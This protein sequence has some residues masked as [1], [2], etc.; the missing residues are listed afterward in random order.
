VSIKRL[1]GAGIYGSKSNKV[2]DQTTTLNDFQSIATVV[3]PSG[4]QS[5]VTFSNI[6]STFTHLQVRAICS[7]SSAPDFANLKVN[8]DTTGS[9]YARHLLYADGG[10]VTAAASTGSTIT[11]LGKISNS[12]TIMATFIVDILDYANANKNKTI[13]SLGGYDSN[14]S[15]EID[16]NSILWMN[17]NAITSLQFTTY[18]SANFVQ[19]SSF[20]LYGIKAAS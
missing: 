18:N 9:N 3:V 7:S 11:N 4:G 5:S 13:R 17:T 2:W 16:F 6:P 14:G 20:A 1:N 15:G 19:Y 8:S 12:S 10:S